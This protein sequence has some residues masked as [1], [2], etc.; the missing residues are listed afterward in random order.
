MMDFDE[1]N[2]HI[3][4]GDVATIKGFEVIFANV[5]SVALALAGIVL[6][7]MLIMG[8]FRYMTAGGDP[9]AAGAARNT[10]TYAIIGMLLLLVSYLILLLI[11]RFTGAKITVFNLTV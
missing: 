9:K 7:V 1:A 10:I 8:G 2:N 4:E 11:E 3:K 6:F 5:L